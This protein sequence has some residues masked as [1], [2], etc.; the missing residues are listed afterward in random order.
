MNPISGRILNLTPR[1]ILIIS[2]SFRPQKQIHRLQR[3]RGCFSRCVPPFRWLGLGGRGLDHRHEQVK[4]RLTPVRTKM[5]NLH[6]YSQYD[7]MQMRFSRTSSDRIYS[8][9]RACDDY[10][11]EYAVEATLNMGWWPVEKNYHDCRSIPRS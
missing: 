10:G 6:N 4:E 8:R 9:R 1:L 3:R 11:W 5:S 2:V 7:I